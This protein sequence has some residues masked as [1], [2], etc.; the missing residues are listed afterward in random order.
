MTRTLS[1]LV[2]NRHGELARVVGLFA[3]RAM[4]VES[5][6]VAETMDPTVSRVTLV[7]DGDDHAVSQIVGQLERQVRV[8]GVTDMSAYRHVERELVLVAVRAESGTAR[9]EVLSLADVFRARVV[10][11][12]N[13]SLII[14]ITGTE[15]K[16]EGLVDVLR[17]FGI[18]EMV[19][20]GIVAM[21]RGT[22]GVGANPP[23]VAA[24][25]APETADPLVAYSV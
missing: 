12:A 17:P 23:R 19:R 20:T 15:D 14:E 1:I 6:C 11:V 2:E 25:V 10:D 9:Q 16:L 8:I 18:I 7:A 3:A 21:R 22:A 24:E 4:N 13:D 5:L